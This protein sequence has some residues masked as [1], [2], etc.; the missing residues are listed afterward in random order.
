M[1]REKSTVTL[2]VTS[3]S[4][5]ALLISGMAQSDTP[6]WPGVTD[7]LTGWLGSAA[8]PT[9]NVVWASRPVARSVR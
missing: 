3:P 4:W 8:P 2:S 7:P 9:V 6:F 1:G 5:M